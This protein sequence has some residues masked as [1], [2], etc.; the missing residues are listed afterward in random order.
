MRGTSYS[1][2]QTVKTDRKPAA[3]KPA[4]AM[5]MGVCAK[6]QTQ[7][8]AQVKVIRSALVHAASGRKTIWMGG[9]R[10]L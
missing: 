5:H 6:G 8:Q 7:T 3:Q 10:R 1:V 9:E 4:V 2:L